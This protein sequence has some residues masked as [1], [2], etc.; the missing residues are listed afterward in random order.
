MHMDRLVLIRIEEKDKSKIFKN[1]RH[2]SCCLHFALQNYNFFLTYARGRAEKI[3]D[4]V[5]RSAVL[6]TKSIWKRSESQRYTYAIHGNLPFELDGC[7]IGLSIVDVD[8][9]VVLR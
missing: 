2:N 3:A 7:T 8:G 5:M 4:H 9:F 6:R 1:L